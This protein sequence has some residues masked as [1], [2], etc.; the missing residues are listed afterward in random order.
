MI[1][2]VRTAPSGNYD[3][4][5]SI[6]TNSHSQNGNAT[7]I[8]ELVSGK[9]VHFGAD[10]STTFESTVS[11]KKVFILNAHN[12]GDIASNTA[13]YGGTPA[14]G[15]QTY[16]FTTQS[17]D[18]W[19]TVLSNFDSSVFEMVITIGDAASK[20]LHSYT[21]ALTSP[22]YGVSTFHQNWSHDGGWNTGSF[23]VQIVTGA[24]GTHQHDLQVK[25]LSYYNSNNMATGYIWLRRLY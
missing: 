14:A 2:G 19:R 8:S 7:D 17:N 6:Y 5:L 16:V 21:G 11:A 24:A 12:I 13:D 15:I 18:T 1:T 10:Q 25:F 4:G 9:V 23:S 3:G 22:A 20:D